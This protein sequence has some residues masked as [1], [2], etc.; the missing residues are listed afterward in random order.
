MRGKFQTTSILARWRARIIKRVLGLVVCACVVAA[1]GRL[2]ESSEMWREQTAS[3]VQTVDLD[4][5]LSELDPSSQQAV[6][7][8][9]ILIAALRNPDT[10]AMLRERSSSLLARIGKPAQA[11]VPVLIE[12]LERSEA[13]TQSATVDGKSV[14]GK[15]DGKSTPRANSTYWAMKSLGVFGSVAA[16][17]VPVV[18]RILKSPA[19]SPKLRVLAAD[20]MGQLRTSA[21]IGVLTAE[22]MKPRRLNDYE[23]IVL[24]QTIIDGLALVGPLAV[25]AIPALSRE[26]EDENADVRRKACEALGALGPRAEGAMNSLMD[27]L[28]LDEDPAVKDAAANSLAQIGKSA[29]ASLVDL[30]ERG[31]PELQWRAARSLGQM[32]KA[33]ESAIPP[34]K[35]AF[36]NS[37]LQVRIE[38]AEAVWK[39]SKDAPAIASVLVR[40]LSE[41]DRQV[42]HRAAELLVE[43]PALPDDAAVSLQKISKNGSTNEQRAAAYVIRERSRKDNQ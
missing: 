20:T 34:L 10:D 9:P 19:T 15:P 28:I 8:V 1:S 30:L 14:D 43:L 41:N 37:S 39:I 6:E 27:R 31:G 22:L 18:A 7:A 12:I 3:P 40:T 36:D 33:A 23:T 4:Q 35:L 21:A 42:R 16:D 29:A 25:G 32:E 17:A 24:R 5:L 13:V 38:A 2:A 26:T 11:A